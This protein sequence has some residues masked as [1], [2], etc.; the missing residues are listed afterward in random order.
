MTNQ[1]RDCGTATASLICGVLS[2][3]CLCPPAAIAAVI[4]GHKALSAIRHSSGELLGEGKAIAGLITGYINLGMALFM[5]PLL[6][7]MLL[8]ALSNARRQ[9]RAIQDMNNLKQL[10]LGTIMYVDDNKGAFPNDLADVFPY[11]GAGQ[12]FVCPTRATTAPANADEVRAGQCDYVYMGKGLVLR[13]VQRSQDTPIICTKP[14]MFPKQ[15]N[16][17]FAD[18]HVQCFK[19][20]DQIPPGVRT[21]I[22]SFVPLDGPQVDTPGE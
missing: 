1:R 11:V 13:D 10:A 2:L 17:A 19:N 14:G 4:C 22:E 9:A 20:T 8:P 3:V 7:A 16:V 12:V 21:V 18:G 15:I 6:A 5:V